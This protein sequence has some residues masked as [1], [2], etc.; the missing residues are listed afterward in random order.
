MPVDK[1]V[2]LRQLDEVLD[3]FNELD[4]KYERISGYPEMEEAA[5]ITLL[6]HALHLFRPPGEKAYS[7]GTLVHLSSPSGPGRL[8]PLAGMVAALRADYAADRLRSVHELIHA[9][10]FSDFL[11]MATHLLDQGYKDPAAV[12]AGAVLEEHIRKL[13]DRHS[14]PTTFT[15]SAGDVRPKKLDAMNADLAR[16]GVYNT[17]EQKDITAQAGVRNAAAHGEYAKYT[18]DQ[19]R[20]MIVSVRAFIARHPA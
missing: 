1:A 7:D 9:D 8:R 4:K 6:T 16:A 19:V 11:E 15:D 18:V 13:C 14:V 17:I 10:M 2:L 20:Q 5:V 3:R 12:T